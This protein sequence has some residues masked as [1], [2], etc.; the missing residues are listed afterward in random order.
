MSGKY[1]I[2]ALI[3]L[4][5]L[6]AK[7]QH[8]IVVNPDKVVSK[9][10]PEMWGVFFEDINM[11]ADGGIYAELIKNRS[12]EFYKPLMG[13]TTRGKQLKEGDLL[14]LN[15]KEKD[16]NNPRFLHVTSRAAAK[17]DLSIANEGFKGIG[18]KK[19]LTY[20]FSVYYRQAA[21]GVKLHAELVDSTGKVLGS[22]VLNPE[23]AD[24]QWANQSVSF[25]AS[26]TVQKAKFTLWFEGKGEI[27][28]DIIS[29]FPGDTWKKRKGGLRSD[30]VQ[31]LADMKPGFIRFPG[32]CIVEGYDLSTRY[33]WKKTVGPVANRKLIVNRWNTEFAH[34]PAPDYYQTFG[35][36][37]FEYFQLS[38]DIGAE[39]LPILNCGMAC[40]FNSAELVPL[41][42]LEPYIQDALD[43]VEFAN[44]D[45]NT[46]WG[47]VR[48]E[49]GHPAPFNLKM[50]G[51]GNE[52]WGPQYLER[53]ALFTKAM[54]DRYPEIKLIN[55]SGT[56]PEGERFDLLNTSLRKMKADIIDEHYYRSP[57]WFLKNATRYDS[58]DRKGSKVFAGEYAAQSVG[59]TK[60]ANKNNWQC[61]I[62]EAAFMTG[63]E[64]NAE[65]VQMASYAPLFAQ[66]EGWQWTPDMIWVDNLHVYGTP[67]Y[68]VQQ[69]YSLNKGTEVVSI[70]AD[71]KVIAGQDGIYASAVTDS[72][73]GELIVKVINTSA[74]AV[75]RNV[76]VEG[77]KKVAAKGKLTVMQ[78]ANLDAVNSFD[79]A[80]NL[81]PK[82]Q[83]IKIK[84]NAVSLSMQP[85]SFNLLRVPVK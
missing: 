37:F 38:E 75:T 29:L 3:A 46:E 78:N 34:R 15:R 63:L 27:D 62:A 53:L 51:V 79:H 21:P 24:N 72:K 54:K 66:A 4:G 49:M 28:L 20:D 83:D 80:I 11:G 76:V 26:E 85:Y 2:T 64:R 84:N 16:S 82:Q 13:W 45:V 44:G 65:V 77:G 35:L 9:V 18:V 57:D 42:E 22:A 39:P 19:G 69:L 48:A 59:T 14:V 70:L 60:P 81:S 6:G 1:L 43:L 50:M 73:T 58:Y 7:A 71:Q 36:G 23:R 10:Q 25:T 17:G 41:D 31:M 61:A 32:G 68:Y 5:A 33:Q 74:T 56:D 30:M 47:K 8:T 40:Q 52:N 12:F 67:N 55:S